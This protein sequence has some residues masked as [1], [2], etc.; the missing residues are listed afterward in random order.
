MKMC[1]EIDYKTFKLL[2]EA[3][4][5][6]QIEEFNADLVITQLLTAYK[7]QTIILN[8]QNLPVVTTLPED[9]FEDVIDTNEYK[10]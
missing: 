7:T 1:I 5:T 4:Q 2:E 6:L 9:P 8:N 10:W 3:Q